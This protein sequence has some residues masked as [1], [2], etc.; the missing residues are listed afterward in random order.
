MLRNKILKSVISCI[1]LLIIICLVFSIFNGPNF[2][3][4]KYNYYKGYFKQNG[5]DLNNAIHDY[6]KAIELDKDYPTAYIYQEE[7]LI[8]I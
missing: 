5:G 4:V 7:V 8:W 1:S 3:F 6:T 2:V